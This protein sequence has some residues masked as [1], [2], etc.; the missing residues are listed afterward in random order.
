MPAGTPH[1]DHE[2]RRETETRHAHNRRLA[3]LAGVGT[4]VLLGVLY[5]FFANLLNTQFGWQL[6]VGG[7]FDWFFSGNSEAV[8][9][10]PS[11]ILMVVFVIGLGVLIRWS[12]FNQPN[13]KLQD[14][15]GR[16]G[17]SFLPRN[18]ADEEQGIS[19]TLPFGWPDQKSA[20]LSNGFWHGREMHVAE[21]DA[22]ILRLRAK[23]PTSGW[24][25]WWTRGD[26]QQMAT[27][28]DQRRVSDVST[29]VNRQFAIFASDPQTYFQR[30]D[31][32]SIALIL[33]QGKHWRFEIH[34]DWVTLYYPSRPNTKLLERDLLVL[35]QLM[36]RLER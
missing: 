7:G 28:P 32:A 8:F 19:A 15:A 36:G 33:D 27:L 2:Y 24:V 29:D 3:V 18:G 31:P 5:I 26:V 6:P 35:E 1:D 22:V 9:D 11:T 25:V 30:F 4:L 21:C 34:D 17:L 12:T 16:Y 14:F 10:L 13:F 20:N 23:K